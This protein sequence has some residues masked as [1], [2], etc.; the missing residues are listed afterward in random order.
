MSAGGRNSPGGLQLGLLR[1]VYTHIRRLATCWFHQLAGASVKAS[2]LDRR[3]LR[4]TCVCFP[5]TGGVSPLSSTQGSQ[6]HSRATS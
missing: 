5:R 4:C 1:L 3:P 6:H 2:C